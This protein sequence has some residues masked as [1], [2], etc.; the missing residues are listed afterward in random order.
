M[1]DLRTKLDIPIRSARF[2]GDSLQGIYDELERKAELSRKQR[3]ADPDTRRRSLLQPSRYKEEFWKQNEALQNAAEHSIDDDVL[4]CFVFQ[5][6]HERRRFIVT[7]PEDFWLDC[8]AI[9]MEKRVFYEVIPESSPCFLY[10]DLEFETDINKEKDGVRMARTV[11]DVTCAYIAKYWQ[12][13]CNRHMVINL[14]SSRPGKFSKHLIFSTKDVAFENNFRVGYLVKMICT[15]ITNFLSDP[16]AVHDVLSNFNRADLEELFV[17]T[18]KGKR[19]FVDTN[20][21]TKNRHFRVYKATKWGKNSHLV[22]APDCEYT[23]NKCPK[24]KEMEVFINSL[25]SYLPNKKK[26]RLFSFDQNK[27]AQTQCYAQSAEGR[28]QKTSLFKEFPKSPYPAL[29]RYVSD[30]VK[31]GKVRDTKYNES[32]QIITYEIVGNRYCENIGR[33]HKSNNVY[34]IVDLANKMMYQKCHDEDCAGFFSTPKKL[35]ME[36]T[37]YFDD[38]MDSLFCALEET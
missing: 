14:D 10:Y 27:Q 12:Y 2:Y 7:Y 37:F 31:P 24:N 4:C 1:D 23:W 22:Q 20:V 6:E 5:D 30:F 29:D 32:I 18:N 26:L 34:F 9:N 16:S 15:E 11:I 28:L 13:S 25:V 33:W 19:L 3:P 36:V 35:P 38:E 21:Y 17:E 8:E